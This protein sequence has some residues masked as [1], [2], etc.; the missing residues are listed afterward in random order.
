MEDTPPGPV[1]GLAQAAAR[2]EQLNGTDRVP[3]GWYGFAQPY[4]WS[5]L[6][7]SVH[8]ALTQR[9]PNY[10]VFQVKEK[11]GGL[12]FYCSVGVEPWAQALIARAEE[13]AETTCQLTGRPG[14]RLR[15]N[16]GGWA[17]TLCDE[18]AQ[19]FEAGTPLWELSTG[20]G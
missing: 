2:L 11:F 15:T 13:R 6:V 1:D 10:Q 12:R 16:P 19:A 17:A 8:D 7:A 20:T 14:A 4:G 9:Y 3:S 18:L 5:L